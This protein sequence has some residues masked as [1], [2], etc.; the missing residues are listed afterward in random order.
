VNLDGLSHNPAL[1]ALFR[2][3]PFILLIAVVVV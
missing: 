2:V 3:A 1:N